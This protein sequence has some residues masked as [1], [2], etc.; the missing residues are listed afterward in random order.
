MKLIIYCFF[1]YLVE[2]KQKKR[3]IFII[4]LLNFRFLKSANSLFRLLNSVYFNANSTSGFPYYKIN[5]I[6]QLSFE[7]KRI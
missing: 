4:N 5:T 7:I 2:K 6:N 3:A 1:F